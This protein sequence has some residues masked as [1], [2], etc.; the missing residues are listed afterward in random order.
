M[1]RSVPSLYSDVVAER[2][3]VVV[4]AA[5]RGTRMRSRL[6]KVLHHLAGRALVAHPVA[7]ATEATGAT[8]VVVVAPDQEQAVAALLGDAATLVTQP[9]AR[10]TGDALRSVPERL[11]SSGTVVVLSGDVPL[12]RAATLGALLRAH[13]D[14][15][16][17]CTL[18]AVES[19]DP[20]GL[21]RVVT[22]PEG[23]ATRVVEERDLEAGSP[24]AS[25]RLCNAG[26]YAF[27]GARLWPALERLTDDNAQG[28]VYL[29]DVVALLAPATV[30]TAA[31]AEEALGVNDRR[32]LAAAETALRRRTLDGLML[33]GVTVEDPATTYVDAGVVVGPD[34]VLR[35][36]SVL[37]GGTCIG[38]GCEIGPM[39]RL[40]DVRAGRG[41]RIGASWLEG[42][43]LGDGVEVGPYARI[44]PGTRLEEGVY[45]GTHAEVKNSTVGAGSKVS[46]FSCVLDSDLGREVN[47]SAGAVTCS[48]DGFDKA[49]IS[50]GDGVFV[51][52]DC[53]LVAPLRVG[54]GA[55][56]AAGSVITKDVPA[57]ALAVERAEQR[58]IAGWAERRR[59]RV[60]ST[61]LGG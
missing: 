38:E 25:S 23:R 13:A 21:G 55:Y 47:F 4:L 8:P 6:P 15:G 17:A 45:I 46:H 26:V 59:A 24:A 28:E 10:G 11:R 58:N 32:Q 3:Q 22:D 48:Y 2:S 36:M 56:L 50:I 30:V 27:Q 44:R 9:Q 39:A 14:G 52:S 5:G 37:R 31:D 40:S 19:H 33:Q 53:M 16:A 57:G 35:P 7:A 42:C 12:V 18:L 43:E 51:G 1:A 54:A 61:T 49:R 29:T 60:L 20:A 41:V 34:T